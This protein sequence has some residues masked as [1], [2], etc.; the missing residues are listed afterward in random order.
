MHQN[1]IKITMNYNP[2]YLHF[3]GCFPDMPGLSRSQSVFA[4][5]CTDEK[6]WGMGLFMARESTCHITAMS[7]HQTKLKSITP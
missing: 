6:L 2:H 4:P 7:E 1:T 3:N 5:I